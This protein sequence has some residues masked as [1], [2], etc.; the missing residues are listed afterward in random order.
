M[1]KKERIQRLHAA[2]YE[3]FKSA[4][5]GTPGYYR[6]QGECRA[7]MAALWIIEDQE[8][9]AASPDDDTE[10]ADAYAAFRA[11]GEPRT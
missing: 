1:E 4:K 2:A 6:S 5:V 11:A 10:Q 7:L 9:N 8:E 3:R